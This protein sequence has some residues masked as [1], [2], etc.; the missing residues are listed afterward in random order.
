MKRILLLL[1]LGLVSAMLLA[2][3]GGDD[4]SGD[5]DSGDTPSATETPANGETPSGGDATNTPEP[6]D[7]D[8]NGGNGNGGDG[9]ELADLITDLAGK[10]FQASYEITTES[11]GTEQTGS[12]TIAQDAPRFATIMELEDGTIAIIEDETG[13]YSCF[14]AGTFGTCTRGSDP[15][16]SIFD[17]REVSEDAGDL[18]AYDKIDDRD[19]NGRD[20]ACW[21]GTDPDSGVESVFCVSKDDGVITYTSSSGFEMSLTDYSDNVDDE[22]FELPYAVQ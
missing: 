19:V 14:G 16:G 8:D 7:D 17:L 20:S 12:M 6:D 2:A 1:S 9:G 5:D 15:Q 3:C 11:Q 13:S 22:I 10:T 21:Q 18:G 4:D